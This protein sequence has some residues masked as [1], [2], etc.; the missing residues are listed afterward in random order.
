MASAAAFT[1][2]I[3]ARL[4]GTITLVLRWRLL[5]PGSRR[6]PWYN[7]AFGRGAKRVLW[8][9]F[10]VVW[11][12]VMRSRRQP[13]EISARVKVWLEAQG[14]YVFG[15][16]IGNILKAVAQEGSIK[17]AA[18]AVGKSYRHIWTR[19]K[20]TERALGCALVATTVGGS[21][22][23]RSELTPQAERLVQ[24]FDDLHRRVCQLIDNESGAIL[25]AISDSRTDTRA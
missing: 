18:A 11:E 7:R 12:S 15:L 9:W 14:D 17:G 13:P 6:V 16:G 22:L 1:S 25:D 5:K 24:Q 4:M 19:I 21:E 2:R 10:L 23:R 20:E 8:E 3:V